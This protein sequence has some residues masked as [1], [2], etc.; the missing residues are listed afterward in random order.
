VI[1]LVGNDE[2]PLGDQRGDVGRISGETHRHHH[3]RLDAEETRDEL[4]G[5]VVEIQSRRVVAGASARDAVSS[6]N[7]LDGV[8]AAT[9]RRGESE[10]VVRRD[11]ERASVTPRELKARVV[12]G[13]GTIEELDRPSRDASDRS[14]EAVV[15]A[16]LEPT[17]V[18]RVKVRVE[19]GVALAPSARFTIGEPVTH[20]VLHEV[21]VVGL[22]EALA[23]EIADVAQDDEQEVTAA[24]S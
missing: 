17:D 21:R 4:L 3:G 19:R 22:A 23:K 18:K 14:G 13:S 7:R 6:D 15:E 20:V 16:L 12:I 10:V 24:I 2:T 1:E 9:G 5:L 11:V 8:R